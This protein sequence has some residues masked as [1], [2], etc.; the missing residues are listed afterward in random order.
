MADLPNTPTIAAV[1]MMGVATVA[2][3]AVVILMFYKYSQRKRNAA[4]M[5]AVAFAFWGLAALATFTGA[6]LHL[7]YAPE[8][9]DIQFSIFRPC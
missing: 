6:I 9:G 1:S 5:I 7:I 4:L 2:I 8:A 3:F